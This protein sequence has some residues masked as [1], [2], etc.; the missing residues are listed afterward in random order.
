MIT[1]PPYRG[2]KLAEKIE[3]GLIFACSFVLIYVF[4]TFI[5]WDW[6]W[7]SFQSAEERLGLIGYVVI[8]IVVGGL[9]S[10]AR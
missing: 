5:Q 7:M 2:S 10:S 9:I 4:V 8:S 3:I 1:R 6:T